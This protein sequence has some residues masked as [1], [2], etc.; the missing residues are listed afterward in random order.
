M[1]NNTF[2]ENLKNSYK[3]QGDKIFYHKTHSMYE[4][5]SSINNTKNEKINMVVEFDDGNVYIKIEF[6]KGI[7]DDIIIKSY[8]LPDD[9]YLEMMGIDRKSY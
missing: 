3:N 7:I 2:E 1:K 4:F 5:A 8:K 6:V 9:F